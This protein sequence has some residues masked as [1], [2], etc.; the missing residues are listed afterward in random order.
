[1]WSIYKKEGREKETSFD[2]K[3][4]VQRF[5]ISEIGINWTGM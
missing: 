4:K 2:E 3:D 5:A 1:M